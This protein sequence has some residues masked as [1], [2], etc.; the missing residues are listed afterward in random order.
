MD[1]F[2]SDS[3]MSNSE[4]EE[5]SFSDTPLQAPKPRAAPPPTKPGGQPVRR[6]FF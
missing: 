5:F 4:R 2:L 3:E 6:R 1:Q